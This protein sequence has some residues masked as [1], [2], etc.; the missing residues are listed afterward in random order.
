VSG[1]PSVEGNARFAR[2]LDQ[3]RALEPTGGTLGAQLAAI[4][5]RPRAPADLFVVSDGLEPLESLHALAALGERRTS[6]TLLLVLAPEE[7]RPPAVGSVELAA[8]EDGELLTMEL[9]ESAIA[10]YR[11]ELE[12]HLEAI[13]L[14]ARRNGW[15]L[16]V[17]DTGADLRELFMAKL[18]G[19]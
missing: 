16:A 14:Q 13:E 1:Q 19:A 5:A 7:M 18:G 6:V 10:A 4:A 17:T 8:L 3:L 9:N 15:Q 12:K 2:L 11:A